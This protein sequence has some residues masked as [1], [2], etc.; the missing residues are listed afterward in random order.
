[1]AT[2]VKKKSQPLGTRSVDGSIFPCTKPGF[3]G[4]YFWPSAIF[5]QTSPFSVTRSIP[6][7]GF[8]FFGKGW[9]NHQPSV[10]SK[11]DVE[12]GDPQPP[13]G[14]QETLGRF[15]CFWVLGCFADKMLEA[16]AKSFCR[17][18]FGHQVCSKLLLDPIRE[19]A[20]NLTSWWRHDFGE[21]FG[22]SDHRGILAEPRSLGSRGWGSQA[23]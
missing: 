8:V 17:C 23:E 7:D 22:L 18:G 20:P 21:A 13:L 14:F 12:W 6:S 3:L 11:A 2:G 4:R 10:F 1:M 16:T 9:R 15:G 19:K 5:F